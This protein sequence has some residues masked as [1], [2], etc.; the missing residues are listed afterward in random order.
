MD[1]APSLVG[2]IAALV[3]LSGIFWVVERLAPGIRGQRRRPPDTRLDVAY[4]FF[5]P[6]VTR[7]V[8][9]GAV[10]LVFVAVAF[11]EGIPLRE[12]AAHA[13]ARDTWVRSWPLW[14]QV[15]AILV[16]ADLLAYWTHRAFHHRRLWAFHAIHHS[17]RELDWLSS[18]RLHPLNDA[19]ARVAQVVP[20]YFLGFD[21]TVL[22]A[23]GPFLTLYAILLHA[24]VRWTFGPLRYVVASP[25]F[26]RWH[27][28]SEDEGLDTNFAGLFPFIDLAFGTF[29]MPPG[30]LPSRFGLIRDDVPTGLLA[31]FL[32]PFRRAPP[33]PAPSPPA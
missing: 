9:K 22:A 14:L 19:A 32:Y 25:V 33:R 21:G 28:T 15:P 24:N 31:Q 12:F 11:G 27:H 20:L 29:H 7:W 13:A 1:A 2:L 10:I 8:T 16:L 26:H 4:W 30:R 6:I 17:S 3:V 23:F 5:T 18:V